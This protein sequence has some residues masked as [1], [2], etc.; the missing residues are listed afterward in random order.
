M[1]PRISRC[2]ALLMAIIFCLHAPSLAEETP[3]RRATLRAVGDIMVHEPQI[4]AHKLKDGGY[5]F[6]SAF[7]LISDSLGVADYTL[8]NLECTVGK[9]PG[10]PH[11][12]YPTFNAPAALLDALQDAGVD[13]LT[14]ANNHMLDRGADGVL[15]TLDELDARGFD[16]VG[17][18]RNEAERETPR[19]AEIC[20]IKIGFLA[21]TQHTNGMEKYVKSES[22][23]HLVN[24]IVRTSIDKDIA[25]LRESGAEII[26]ACVHWGEEYKRKPEKRTRELAQQLV[27][28]GIDIIIGS[29]PHNVQ[30]IEYLD[31]AD[32]R[33]AL[34][35]YSLG[36]FLGTMYDRYAD[37]GIILAFTLQETQSGTIEILDPCFV[38]TYLWKGALRN[39]G[40]IVRVVPIGKHWKKPLR[41]MNKKTFETMRRSLRDT[42]DTL[43]KS[44]VTLLDE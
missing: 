4:L 26:I 35:A 36:N 22:L 6:A 42:R 12:G 18:N 32:G 1:R 13:M 9:M 24:R 30:P 5:E 41:T 43:K 39:K 2:L 11:T 3:L 19:T 7:E 27:D 31:A 15:L 17:A 29:H 25:A 44:P 33:R 16:H 10:K 37:G 23:P 40:R 14:L 38:P 20:G 34:V 8:G 21:Y 28:A